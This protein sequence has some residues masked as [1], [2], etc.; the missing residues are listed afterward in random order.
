MDQKV[1]VED[2]RG[3]YQELEK[4]RGPVSLLMLLAPDLTSE[5]DWNVIV[6][7]AGYDETDRATAI[8]ELVDLLKETLRD[9]NWRKILRVT[10][11]KTDDKFVQAVNWTHPAEGAMVPLYSANIS[12]VDIPKAMILKSKAAA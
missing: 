12:G 3:V 6:S 2:F 8:R 9:E 1:L 7:A 10:V 4:R 5:S 11:L